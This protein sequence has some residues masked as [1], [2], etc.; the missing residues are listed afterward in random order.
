MDVLDEADD[1]ELHT[2]EFDGE[3]VKALTP[4]HLANL[5]LFRTAL[6]AAAFVHCLRRFIAAVDAC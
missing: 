6:R 3:V 1:K 5:L 4:E 2:D